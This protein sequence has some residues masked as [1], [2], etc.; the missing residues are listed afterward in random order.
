M[1]LNARPADVVLTNDQGQMLTPEQNG[2]PIHVTGRGWSRIFALS[3]AVPGPLPCPNDP[4]LLGP[5]K[6]PGPMRTIER[7]ASG[8]N[9][10]DPV[11]ANVD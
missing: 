5:E 11:G 4:R 7:G 3:Q 6:G 8:D 1:N 2:R 10:F 9:E